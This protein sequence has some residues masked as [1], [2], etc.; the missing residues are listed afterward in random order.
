MSLQGIVGESSPFDKAL[1]EY[2]PLK[3]TDDLPGE[4]GSEQ[5]INAIQK[6]IQDRVEQ[7]KKQGEWEAETYGKDP[8]ASISIFQ[9]MVIYYMTL[10]LKRTFFINSVNSL[11]WH[12]PINHLLIYLPFC[13][14]R[15]GN[16]VE[17][18]QTV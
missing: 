12:L 16:A 6:R 7:L 4:D 13:F 8:L 10:L 18:M 2:D 14:T 11:L 5:K 15:L 9:T 1:D 17:S 3:N